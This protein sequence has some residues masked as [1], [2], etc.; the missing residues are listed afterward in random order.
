MV[1]KYPSTSKSLLKNSTPIVQKSWVSNLLVTYLFIRQLFPTPPSPK[2]ITLKSD[3]FPAIVNVKSFGFRTLNCSTQSSLSPSVEKIHS[4]DRE[5]IFHHNARLIIGVQEIS[6]GH[7][8][9]WAG[10][11]ECNETERGLEPA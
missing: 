7:T 8:D 6:H 9:L 4:N 5:K 2:R 1:P 11:S 10:P 3:D